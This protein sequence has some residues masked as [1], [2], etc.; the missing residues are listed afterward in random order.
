MS[1]VITYRDYIARVHLDTQE[2]ILVGEVVN[3]RGSIVFHGESV[4]ELEDGF[5]LAIDEYLA[6]CADAGVEPE[7][8]YSGKFQLRLDP[9]THRVAAD[10]AA[11]I[12]KSLN[13]YVSEVVANDARRLVGDD[14]P[15]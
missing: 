12:G 6:A 9:A 8:P 14:I 13:A 3:A 7:R 4:K 10:A 15:F 1:N 5:H 11:I 2:G